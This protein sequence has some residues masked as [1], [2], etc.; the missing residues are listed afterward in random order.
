MCAYNQLP[1]NGGSQPHVL[2][3]PEST[4]GLQIMGHGCTLD[5][6]A[7]RLQV[8]FRII[9]LLPVQPVV[10]KLRNHV[11]ADSVLPW[12]FWLLV[13][14]LPS[15]LMPV[16]IRG[17]TQSI[18]CRMCHH[19]NRRS[20]SVANSFHSKRTAFVVLYSGKCYWFSFSV[21][22]ASLPQRHC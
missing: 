17:S 13:H 22:D 10:W 15:R 8:S 4:V 2:G 14:G 11:R 16:F 7:K 9:R 18:R 19:D 21:F 6:R 1:T 3:Q 12:C 20:N 5:V